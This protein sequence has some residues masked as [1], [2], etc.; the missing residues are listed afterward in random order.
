MAWDFETDPEYQRKLDWADEFVREE[1]EPLDLVWEHEQFVPLDGPR[2]AA[3]EPLKKQVREQGLWATHLGP[4]LGGQGYGQLKLALLNEILGRSSWAPIVFGCQAPDT[5]NAEIIAHYGTPEQKRRYLQPLLDGELFSSYSMTEP[6]AGADPTR[7]ETRATRDGDDWIINGWKF[8]SSNAKTA[9]FLIVMAVTNPDVSP[10]QGMSMFLVPTGTPGI[11]IVRNV[12][13]YGEPLDG[14]SHALIHYDNVRVPAEALLGGEGQA[15]VIA[16]TRLG[17]GRIHHAMRTIGL[18]QQALDMMCERALSRE[19]AGSRL[20]DKQFVQG[21]IADSYAQLAQFR[22]FVLHTA[23]KIDKYND[24]KKVR[25]DIAT[26]KI[27]MP[28]VLHDIAWRAMQVHGALGTTNEMPFFRMIHGAGVMGLADGPTEVHKGT[29]AKQV[30]R[31]Y[32]PTDGMWPTQ[33]I[34]AKQQAAR[35]KFAEY[36]EHEAGNL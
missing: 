21:Y 6:Q 5:G 25:K 32:E 14:G 20:A 26:A 10:Y 15:F 7:F 12:G 31:D 11:D 24:Y 18:A 16:Q 9:A 3:I 1:V 8:F 23:W 33:W 19:T 13:L 29:V 36:L 2:R 17:G 27:I 22:L 34:P 35:E 30:L 4:D 28:T